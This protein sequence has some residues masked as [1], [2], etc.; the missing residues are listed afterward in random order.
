MSHKNNSTGNGARK[1]NIANEKKRQQLNVL[2]EINS[3]NRFYS[4]YDTV[5]TYNVQL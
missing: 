5:Q 2:I 4:N 1:I 3:H